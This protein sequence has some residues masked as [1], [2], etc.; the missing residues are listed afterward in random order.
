MNN[1]SITFTND[2]KQIKP[3][4]VLGN[5]HSCF[6]LEADFPECKKICVLNTVSSFERIE[7]IDSPD[8]SF[9]FPKAQPFISL[10]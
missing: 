6:A 7:S 2:N 5:P 8:L 3:Y 1:L 10:L 4:L 9:Q